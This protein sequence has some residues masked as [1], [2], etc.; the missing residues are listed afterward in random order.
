MAYLAYKMLRKNSPHTVAAENYDRLVKNVVFG[1]MD[2]QNRRGRPRKEWMDDIKEWGRVDVHTLSIMA[3]DRSE[4]KRVVVEALDTKGRKPME[5]RRSR[6]RLLI[7]Q[8]SHIRYLVILK[9]II[10]PVV[11]IVIIFLIK[12]SSL[13]LLIINNFIQ[14]T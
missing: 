10:N 12:S 13:L 14:H 9:I 8:H 4:W 3:R 6:R 2:E 5:G 11:F 7:Q 1:I